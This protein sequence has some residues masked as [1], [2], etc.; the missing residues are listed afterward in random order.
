M[1]APEAGAG[2]DCAGA[3]G[4]AV[5][6]GGGA[7][8]GGGVA[9]GRLRAGVAVGQ[10][11]LRPVLLAVATLPQTVQETICC[12]TVRIM[13]EAW[14]DHIY[15]HRIKFTNSRILASTANG[16]R[17]RALATTCDESL[18]APGSLLAPV[19]R[20]RTSRRLGLGRLGGM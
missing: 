15:M 16:G 2:A 14:L 13:C 18:A 8:A 12:M 17:I 19:R 7:R 10:R 1:L 11:V 3:H 5:G 6:D 9:R 20:G 4:A